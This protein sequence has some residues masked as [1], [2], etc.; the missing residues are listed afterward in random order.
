[1]EADLISINVGGDVGEVVFPFILVCDLVYY[2]CSAEI[3][4]VG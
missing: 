2:V 3:M 1:V 4:C